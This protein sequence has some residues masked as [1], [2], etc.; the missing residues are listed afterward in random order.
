MVVVVLSLVVGLVV[1]L[2][3]GGRLDA[4]ARV[5]VVRPWLV[6]AA[7]CALLLGLVG[8]G[9]H[10][11]GA[12]ASVLCVAAFLAANRRLPG[13]ALVAAGLFLNT[14]VVVANGAMPVSRSAAARAGVSTDTLLSDPRYVTADAGTRLEPLGDVVPVPLPLVP[15]VVSPGDVLVASGLALFAAV[16]PVRARRTLEARRHVA[17]TAG[18]VPPAQAPSPRP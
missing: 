6:L 9:A 14:V 17:V 3:R 5:R 8:S 2:L 7:V 16:A 10:V 4:L 15:A 13:L 18:G 12:V 1:G 11:V